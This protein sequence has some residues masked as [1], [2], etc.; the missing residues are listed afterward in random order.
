MTRISTISN[1]GIDPLTK[2]Y[3]DS[4]AIALESRVSR[5]ALKDFHTA[6]I[7][8]FTEEQAEA[9]PP[10]L[11]H[12]FLRASKYLHRE[13]L[14]PSA[15]I[16]FPPLRRVVHIDNHENNGE[17]PVDHGAEKISKVLLPL[18]IIP[19][20]LSCNLHGFVDDLLTNKLSNDFVFKPDGRGS[21]RGLIRVRTDKDQ[22]R[23]SMLNH[24][25][26]D[27]NFSH[28]SSIEDIL[29]YCDNNGIKYS[30]LKD[31]MVEL[32]LPRN[33]E[34]VAEHLDQI[35]NRAL[36]EL[37]PEQEGD[38]PSFNEYSGLVEDWQN[39]LKI[40]DN[41]VEAR[42]FLD[43]T[44]SQA[45]LTKDIKK[46]GAESKSF[47]KGGKSSDMVNCGDEIGVW[48]NMHQA[49]IDKLGLTCTESEF[50]QYMARLCSSIAKEFRDQFGAFCNE[51]EAFL[52]ALKGQNIALDIAWKENEFIKV[53]LN[54][55]GKTIVVPKPVLMEI[56]L[57][58]M[59]F[60]AMD[61]YAKKHGL[62]DQ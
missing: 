59:N 46:N 29:A 51:Q 42:Y 14:D 4:M 47:L 60:K 35:F 30:G 5:D 17:G 20:S 49:L 18:E 7:S 16:D 13:M 3:K 22:I 2:L 28:F 39:L 38:K 48:P 61:E 15:L 33:D 32:V 50:N 36:S 31:P 23:L 43:L 6:P 8:V 9:I 1:L 27:P 62:Y 25:V 26:L 11:L 54:R 44:N 52:Q 21:A 58:G 12:F 37:S 53:P 55:K 41:V 10:R 45:K 56:T 24:L 19:K 34:K 40:N 57:N